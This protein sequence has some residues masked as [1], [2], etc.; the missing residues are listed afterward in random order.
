MSLTLNG[1]NGLTM[2]DGS[3]IV[4]GEQVAK[5]WVNFNGTGVVAIR[6]SYNVASITDNGVGDYTI[7]FTS[8]LA[9]ANYVV[10]TSTDSASPGSGNGNIFGI[11]NAGSGVTTT[12]CRVS[13]KTPNSPATPQDTAIQH[14]IILS[15]Q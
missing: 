2:P 10:S 14:V 7:N 5:A 15:G 13:N 3:P 4:S 9:N 6:D 8:A 1:T 11:Y 12:A